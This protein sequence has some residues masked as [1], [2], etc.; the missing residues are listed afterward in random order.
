MKEGTQLCPLTPHTR[1]SVTHLV[2]LCWRTQ[3]TAQQHQ[4]QHGA[5]RVPGAWGEHPGSLREQ[6]S[7]PG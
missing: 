7:H 6:N 5:H 4:Q 2:G 3:D 1:L